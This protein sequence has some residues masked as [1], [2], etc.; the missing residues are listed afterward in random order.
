MHHGSI[1]G[2]DMVVTVIKAIPKFI[3]YCLLSSY[4]LK[5]QL[6]LLTLRAAQPHLNAQ[7]LGDILIV[8]PNTFEEQE[9]IAEYLER[10]TQRLDQLK[11]NLNQQISTLEAYKKSLIYE[12]VTGKKRVTL[13]HPSDE[14]ALA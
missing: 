9:K 5:A 11:T 13:D 4:V 2:Y 6:L 3:S 12:C 14:I 10:E 1:A 8:L 7:E